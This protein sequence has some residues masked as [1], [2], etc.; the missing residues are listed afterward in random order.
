MFDATKKMVDNQTGS[1]CVTRQG[2]IVGIITERDYLNKVVH[3]GRTSHN[4]L[5]DDICMHEDELLVAC[6][7]DLVEDCLTM[8]VSKDIRDLPVMDEHSGEIVA[9]MSL[10]DIAKALGRI[11]ADTFK[12]MNELRVAIQMPIHDG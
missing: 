5:V 7:S 11:Q 8:M 3:E 9:L 4:T 1:L 10:K 6:A 2:E 12:R